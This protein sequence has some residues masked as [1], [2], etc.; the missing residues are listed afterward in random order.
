[1]PKTTS[2]DLEYIRNLYAPQDTLLARIDHAL[3]AMDMPIHIGPEEGKFLQLLIGL[4]GV[5]TIVEIG[6]LAGY[7]TLWMARA[8]PEDGHI[9]TLDK[10][11]KHSEMARQFFI[12]SDVMR[13]ISTLE[14]DAHKTLKMLEDKAP[15]DMIFIDADKISYPD[16]LDWAD[17]NIRSG[18]LIVADNTLLF[19][20][21]AKETPP[22]T[23]AP[24]TWKAMRSFN[25]RLADSEKYFTVM[26]PTNDGLTVAVKF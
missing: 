19:G 2:A 23:I 9:Y 7:S 24:A 5:K 12:E 22:D 17:K 14:G 25:E 26:I 10:D 3:H 21:A 15:F 16:Y 1:M 20:A 4:H 18:G 6:T 8:L 11:P 13:R